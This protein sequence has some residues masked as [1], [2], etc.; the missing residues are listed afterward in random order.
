MS[1]AVPSVNRRPRP[2]AG[3]SPAA[4]GTADRDSWRQCRLREPAAEDS[5]HRPAGRVPRRVS[6]RVPRHRRP[7]RLRQDHADQHDRRF[8]EAPRRDDP[9][10][11]PDRRRPRCRP[12]HGVPG[13]RGAAVAHRVQE[14]HVRAGEP[15]PPPVEG[16]VAGAHRPRARA[17]RSHRLREVLS[18]RALRRHAPAG[19]H[20]PSAGVGAGDPVDGRAVRCRRRHD[21]RGDAGRVREDHRRDGPDRLLHHPLDRRGADTRATGWW[22]CRTG[23][24]GSRR[25]STSTCPDPASTRASSAVRGSANCASTSGACSRPRRS[26]RRPEEGTDEHGHTADRPIA[27]A[28]RR[29]V[30]ESITRS[31][32]RR[33]GARH[34]G[35]QPDDVLRRSGS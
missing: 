5:A 1:Q 2:S 8:H 19:R 35:G 25:S 26:A 22:W 16:R 7:V 15:A 17:G 28:E 4:A 24:A 32:G 34:H 12:G 18:L 21:A 27:A 20:R 33:S 29:S 23:R 10:R 6:R 31:A 14:R 9:G 13:L 11:R 30:T 3:D